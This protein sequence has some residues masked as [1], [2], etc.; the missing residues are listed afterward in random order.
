M[1]SLCSA[2]AF[3]LLAS[4]VLAQGPKPKAATPIK[5]TTPAQATQAT[6]ATA[7]PEA[8]APQSSPEAEGR[9]ATYFKLARN[10]EF[11][12]AEQAIGYYQGIVIA[13]PGTRAAAAAAAR[14]VRLKASR[15]DA[16]QYAVAKT[17]EST[18]GARPDEVVRAPRI[19]YKS[20]AAARARL[21]SSVGSAVD[22][23]ASQHRAA[24]EQHHAAVRD[25]MSGP[26][27]VAPAAGAS[28]GGAGGTVHVR[29]Y[30]RSNGT[31]VQP[32]TRSLPR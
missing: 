11:D 31:Y 10:L 20:Q 32:H 5:A 7:T 1:R 13:F 22:G 29:G 6:K 4:S 8:P 28:V 18:V 23:M 12:Q 24:S 26:R 14:L 9:A 3:A 15:P 30:T 19:R 17:F 16:F 27:T 21:N 2:A 25:S